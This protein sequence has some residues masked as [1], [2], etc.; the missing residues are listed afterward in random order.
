ML[1]TSHKCFSMCVYCMFFVQIPPRYM[2]VDH[3]HLLKKYSSNVLDID[4]L[5]EENWGSVV[6]F[7]VKSQCLHNE[8]TYIC[9][10]T[11][12]PAV[13]VFTMSSVKYSIYTTRQI[14]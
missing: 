1:V 2:K 12:M 5:G 11:V 3:A 14:N 8:C 7:M 13:T 4:I 9:P 6:N 10:V